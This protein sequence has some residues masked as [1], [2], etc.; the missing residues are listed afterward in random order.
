MAKIQTLTIPN[1]NV[2]MEQEELS[3]M[4]VGIQNG[5]ATLEGRQFGSFLQS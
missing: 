3:L 4:P 5:T 2:D 1:A